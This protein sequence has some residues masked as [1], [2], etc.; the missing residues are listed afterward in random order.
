MIKSILLYTAVFFFI[1]FISFFLHE[2][3]IE[4]KDISLAFSL[5]KVYQFHL[6]FSLLV[7]CNLHFFS[8]VDKFFEQLGFVYLGTV[9]LKLILFCI[10][11]YNP[12]F[13]EDNLSM[14]SRVSLFIPMF[15]FLLTEAVF[16]AKILMKKQ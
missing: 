3:Y 15:I 5:K 16:V 14:P 7:C 8:T 4:N 1:F 6:G 12:I 10:I 9:V 11:F 13:T 2:N